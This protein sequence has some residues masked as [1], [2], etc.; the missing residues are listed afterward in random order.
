MLSV[1]QCVQQ[2]SVDTGKPVH[3][4]SISS[5]TPSVALTH[6]TEGRRDAPHILVAVRGHHEVAV[7]QAVQHQ[8][9]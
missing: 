8:D 1:L 7:Y 5:S 3:Q 4:I 9:R 6:R 2:L